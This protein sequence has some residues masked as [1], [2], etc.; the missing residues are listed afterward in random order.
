MLARLD[1]PPGLH[2]WGRIGDTREYLRRKLPELQDR[3]RASG[4]IPIDARQP[5]TTWWTRFSLRTDP[6]VA[7]LRRMHPAVSYGSGPRRRGGTC[8]HMTFRTGLGRSPAASN[9]VLGV[10][11]RR[12]VIKGDLL[13]RQMSNPSDQKVNVPRIDPALARPEVILLPH[14]LSLVRERLIRGPGCAHRPYRPP[15]VE[16]V[17][18]SGLQR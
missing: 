13:Y 12:E 16:A 7:G 15:A 8:S 11:A 14:R 9:R 6:A 2:D 1:A 10:D 5:S 4:A 17:P 3:L 18:A